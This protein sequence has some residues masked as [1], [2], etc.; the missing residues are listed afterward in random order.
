MSDPNA[1]SWSEHRTFAA[2]VPAAGVFGGLSLT[3][4]Q[5]LFGSGSPFFWEVVGPKGQRAD[6]HGSSLLEA[7]RDCEAA[8]RARAKGLV[9]E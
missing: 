4:M 1:V 3:V 8:A 5:P 2:S 6:G 9:K 7:K